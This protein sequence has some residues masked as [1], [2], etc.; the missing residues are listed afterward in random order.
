MSDSSIEL[1]SKVAILEHTVDVLSGEVAAQLR[2]IDALQE[3]L[4]ALVLQVHRLRTGGD[5]I[6]PH[7]T[8]PPHWGG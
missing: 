3:N 4:D 1:Q 5:A 8:R 7:D 2:R 6:E